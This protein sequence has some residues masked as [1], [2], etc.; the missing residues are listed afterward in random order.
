M[1]K[2]PTLASAMT[3][4]PL[5]VEVTAPV[6]DADQLMRK[7]D[8]HHLPV[9]DGRNIVGTLS[10]FDIASRAQRDT[11][12]ADCYVPEPYLV[13]IDVPLEA[14]LTEMAVHRLEAAIVMRH[15]RLA[16][17]FTQHDVCRTFAAHLH[18]AYPP[19]PDDQVA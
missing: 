1:I 16:G 8:I 2:K 13:E 5:A 10:A 6:S 7:H 4:F 17:I 18:A 15:G 9:T 14:V 12:V 3:P 19:P 11:A